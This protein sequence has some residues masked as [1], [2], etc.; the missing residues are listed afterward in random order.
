M[1]TRSASKR[2]LSAAPTSPD[3]PWPAAS[4]DD[5]AAAID[6][7][8]AEAE[9]EIDATGQ[10]RPDRLR[11]LRERLDLGAT[12]AAGLASTATLAQQISQLLGVQG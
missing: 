6:A 4:R 1:T 10:V 9:E 3:R 7:G 2:W 8:L 5:D 12:A 11:R